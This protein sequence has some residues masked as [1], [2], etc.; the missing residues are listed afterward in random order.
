MKMFNEILV[1]VFGKIVV[2]LVD[3]EEFVD[4]NK[5]LFKVDISV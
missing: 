5:L 4:V 2:V 1:G 3:N